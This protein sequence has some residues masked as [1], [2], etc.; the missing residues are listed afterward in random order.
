MIIVNINSQ[1]FRIVFVPLNLNSF[2]IIIEYLYL[3]IYKIKNRNYKSAYVTRRGYRA[4]YPTCQPVK[5]QHSNC[6]FLI[7]KIVISFC[8]IDDHDINSVS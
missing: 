6:A 7:D 5:V 2:H 8:K 4:L 1:N 3:I